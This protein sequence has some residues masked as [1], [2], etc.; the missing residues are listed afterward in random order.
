MNGGRQKPLFTFDFS[1]DNQGLAGNGAS[2]YA[3]KA[4]GNFQQFT[5]PTIRRTTKGLLNE[6]ASSTSNTLP[7]NVSVSATWTISQGSFAAVNPK[8]SVIPGQ[9]AYEFVADNTVGAIRNNGAGTFGSILETNSILIETTPTT[10]MTGAN[11]FMQ[12]SLNSSNVLRFTW[13]FVSG[14]YTNNGSSTSISGGIINCGPGPNGGTLY[15]LSA[16]GIPDVP[17]QG[18]VRR[19]S[20]TPTGAINLAGHSIIVHYFQNEP[21]SVATS[22]FATSRSAEALSLT[23]ASGTYHIRHITDNGQNFDTLN[24]TVASNTYNIPTTIYERGPDI[25]ETLS[26][27]GSAK[28]NMRNAYIKKIEFWPNNST[29][30]H[31]LG[32]SYV[33]GYNVVVYAPLYNYR[34]ATWT[35]DGVSG[36]S[37][38]QQA[39]RFDLTP[40]YYNDILV[41][42]DGGLTDDAA[43]AIASIN[44]MIAHLPN[45][46]WIYM[47]STPNAQAGNE[48][49]SVG[50][51]DYLAK[52]AAIKAAFPNNYVP[53]LAIMQANSTGSTADVS[54]VNNGWWPASLLIDGIV[55]PNDK[56]SKILAGLIRDA[57]VAR[58]Y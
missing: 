46:K 7:F 4:D 34:P 44:R 13:N 20:F 52:C 21:L 27:G 48:K 39:D 42:Y 36:S 24:V 30:Y 10:F 17:S 18:G 35:T 31:I 9:T 16:T 40:Q 3:Q 41:I 2:G 45:K 29:N 14:A 25:S 33:A 47:E 12:S 49:G 37:L 58:K 53:T 6:P 38:A 54:N 19:L 22:P 51:T 1:I 50:Y 43:T 26:G 8:I 23:A 32:D 57:L 15:L 56:A 55:H 5:S 28:L 11:F